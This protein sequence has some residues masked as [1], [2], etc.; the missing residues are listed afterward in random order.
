MIS[1]HTHDDLG[2]GGRQLT[3]GGTCRCTPVEGAMNGI[4]E[5]AGNC[6]LEEVIMAIKV[7]KDI[8]NVH[9]AINH[10]E[11]WRTS[12]LVSQICNMPIPANKSHCW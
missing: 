3:G 9:T 12:Q 10:R 2:P 4:G 5:R 8:L 1:V 11:I 6:S 7:R